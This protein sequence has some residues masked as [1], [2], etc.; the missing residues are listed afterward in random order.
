MSV[1]CFSMYEHLSPTV[2]ISPEIG[3]VP[4]MLMRSTPQ[5]SHCMSRSRGVLAFG[6]D[7]PLLKSIV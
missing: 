5:L 1:A 2:K 6:P 3:S 7:P 4:L